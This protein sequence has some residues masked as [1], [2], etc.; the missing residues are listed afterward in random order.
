MALN[1]EHQINIETINQHQWFLEMRFPCSKKYD[2][3]INWL[4]M[5]FYFFQQE[6]SGFLTIYFPNGQ[7]KVKRE[8]DVD[9]TLVSKISIESTCRKIGS[10]IKN[11]LSEF[12]NHIDR[13]N[14]LSQIQF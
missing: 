1:M 4:Q 8:E 6:Q 10:K 11:S 2:Q 3:F 14:K 9:A 13:Y 7:V 5:E 12:L